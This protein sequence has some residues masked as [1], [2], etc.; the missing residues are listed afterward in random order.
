M[1]RS[2]L[3]KHSISEMTFRSDIFPDVNDR[4]FWDAFQNDELI[5]LAEAEL[6]YGWPVI[7]ATD[8]ME[9][10]ISGDRRIM[11]IPHFD[12]RLA[13]SLSALYSLAVTLIGVNKFGLHLHNFFHYIRQNEKSKII[14]ETYNPTQTY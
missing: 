6:E 12:R 2:F 9:F 14:S 10:K 11:E 5:S 7:K 4:E 8:F 3:R 1:F 13:V